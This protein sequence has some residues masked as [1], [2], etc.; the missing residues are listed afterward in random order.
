MKIYTKLFNLQWRLKVWKDGK[1]P[2]FKSSYVT[3]DNLLSVL[4]PM[5]EE[6]KL[7]AV[8]YLEDNHLIT[9]IKDIESWESIKS[10][11]HI[12]QEDPQKI[13]S[14]ITYW[15][16]YS[17]GAIFNI[18]TDIDD[19]GNSASTTYWKSEATWTKEPK[20]YLDMKTFIALTKSGCT[21]EKSLTDAIIE[22]KFEL[23]EPM[24]KT[25]RHYCDN[26]GEIKDFTK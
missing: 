17:L 22:Y 5:L 7:V 11:F 10:S 13:G 15:K 3:L 16:R 8:H 12:T 25:L 24:K 2:H 21:D 23:T 4:L 14:A 6:E 20:N 26:L 19:D 9:E 1:N 18:I